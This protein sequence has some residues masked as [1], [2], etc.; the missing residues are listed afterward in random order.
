MYRIE[1]AP[2]EETVFRTIEELATGI[3]NGVVKSRARIYHN[4]SQKWLPIEFHPHYKKALQLPATRGDV[5][6]ARASERGRE[7]LS[8][9]APV[10][11][12]PATHA[13]AVAE[14]D[15]ATVATEPAPEPAASE[16]AASEHAASEPAPPVPAKP[17]PVTPS[18]V[19]GLPVI[20]YPQITPVEEPVAEP[21]GESR[22][23]AGRNRR[24]L[25]LAGLAIV[26]IL[27]A[28]AMA[29]ALSASR[30]AATAAA[31]ADRRSAPRADSQ[32]P[33]FVGGPPK[34]PESRPAISIAPSAP[35]S[36][37]LAPIALTRP[38]SSGFAPALDARAIVSTPTA[39]AAS[40]PSGVA[41]IDG[42]PS[43]TPAPAAVD[44]ALPSLPTT[45]SL[46]GTSRPQG[47]SAMKRILR[48]V[49]G[50]RDLPRRP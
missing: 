9:A 6:A 20:A 24:P 23:E 26:L 39:P 17:W 30:G 35:A 10:H 8:F 45:E 2:G 19:L 42:A 28:Y 18:P 33:S 4:A 41:A 43:I 49:N 7:T 44:L 22:G 5:P 12:E 36:V 13:A 16:S 34:A 15:E 40:A 37:A 25:H 31:T 27:G 32:P 3:R 50:G 1:L 21:R 29:S 14:E 11:A 47:D 46:V 48:A 38:A